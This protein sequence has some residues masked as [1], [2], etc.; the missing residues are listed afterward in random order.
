[1]R[2]VRRGR[3]RLRVCVKILGAIATLT[4]LVGFSS[5]ARAQHATGT[6]VPIVTS[7]RE[8]DLI[9]QH[10]GPR[11]EAAFA[12]LWLT[13]SGGLFSQASAF[14]GC[15]SRAEA[16]GN[17]LNGFAVQRHSFLRLAPQLV[18][19]RFSMAGCA[20]DTGTGAGLS[21][22]VPLR[23]QLWLLPSAGVYRLPTPGDGTSP[24]LTSAA[25]VDLVAQL[26]HG[27]T[28]SVG[29]GARSGVGQF[30]ALNFGGSF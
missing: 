15:E 18:L 24:F 3:A 7:A 23:K 21:Y 26:A 17:S 9:A 30:H 5:A 13:L 12:P 28:L 1:M 20:V 8:G 27:G 14:S 25:R 6:L 19:H 29:L 11:V 4:A 16:S 10:V 2:G 22:A